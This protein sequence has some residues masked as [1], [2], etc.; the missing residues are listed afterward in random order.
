MIFSFLNLLIIKLLKHLM[1]MNSVFNIIIHPSES[2]GLEFNP[3][4]SELF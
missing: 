4:E 2:F 1:F 3:S